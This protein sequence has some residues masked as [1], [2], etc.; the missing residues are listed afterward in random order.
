MHYIGLK[1]LQFYKMCHLHVFIIFQIVAIYASSYVLVMTAIDRYLAICYPLVSRKWSSKM[2]HKMVAVAWTLS[3]IFSVPQTFIFSYKLN[4]Y[5]YYDCWGTFNPE[6]TLPVYITTITVLVYIIP[7]IILVFCYGSICIVVWKSGKIGERLRRL[8]KRMRSFEFSDRTKSGQSVVID[9]PEETQFSNIGNDNIA[10]YEENVNGTRN[11][12]HEIGSHVDKYNRRIKV[13]HTELESS[14]HLTNTTSGKVLPNN[15]TT[16]QETDLTQNSCTNG[17]NNNSTFKKYVIRNGNSKH[18]TNTKRILIF[19]LLNITRK[20]ISKNEH[21]SNIQKNSTTSS[22]N[23][24]SK[25]RDV[26]HQGISR[27]KLKTIK[28]TLMVVICYLVCWSPFFIAQMWAVYD[29][30]APFDG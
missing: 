15:T 22:H 16:M 8:S 12:D 25:S 1:F 5:G 21:T 26:G 28:L 7:T 18:N 29:T 14:S 27:G 17:I 9:S 19:N 20:T 10:K 30:N 24:S 6:W 4:R 11:N 2:V 13:L 3:V 23:T